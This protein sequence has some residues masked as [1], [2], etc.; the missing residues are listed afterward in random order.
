MKT[1]DLFNFQFVDREY[2]RKKMQKFLSENSGNAL[3]IKGKRGFGKTKLFHYVMKEYEDHILCYI[4]IKP[5][6]SSM[7]TLT[8]FIINLQN[9]CSKDFISSV[10]EKYTR[11]YNHT[12]KHIY[13]ISKDILPDISKIVSLILDLGYYAITK[14]GESKSPIELINDYIRMILA[15]NK[16]CICID[17]FSRCNIDLAQLFFQIIKAFI[18]DNN[19]KACIVTTS[20][21]IKDELNEAIFTHLPHKEISIKKLDKYNYFYQILEPIFEINQLTEED[22]IFLYHKCEGSPK[23]LCTII[24]KLL[25]KEGITI[26]TKGKARINRSKLLEILHNNRVRFEDG[27]FTS[28]QKWII[29]SFLCLPSKVTIKLMKEL[30]LY[31][32][33]RCFLYNA[34]DETKFDRELLLL[35][36][37]KILNY[38]IPDIISTNHDLD[39]YELTDIFKDSTLREMF[40]QYTYEFLL[41]KKNVPYRQELLCKHAYEA[42]IAG[43]ELLNFRY[44]KKLFYHKR[45]YDAY[46]VL[47]RLEFT[48]HKLNP[49]QR[50]FS[51]LVAYEAGYYKASIKKMELIDF[52]E[53]KF[54]KAKYY[55]LFYLGKNYYN[56][57]NI[58]KAVIML[59]KSLDFVPEGSLKY[60]QTLN[61]LHMYYFEIP[62]KLKLS[63]EIFNHI[64]VTYEDKYPIAWANTMRGCHNFLDNKSA[65]NILERAKKKLDDEL[66]K[67]FIENTQGFVF[68][69]MSQMV[70]A[71]NKFR[72][73]GNIIKRLR[74]HEY[75]YVAN[76]LAL[77]YMIKQKYEIAKT[78]LL[79]ALL[80]N[81]TNYGNLVLQTHLMMC[82]FYLHELD[83]ASY[84]SKI[85][86]EYMAS[87]EVVDP[88]INRKVYM[89]LAIFSAGIKSPLMEVAYFKKAEPFVK[90]SSSEWRYNFLTKEGN[91]EL[92][93]PNAEYMQVI[94]FDP[95]FL[96]YAHD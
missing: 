17:N 91:I 89:N 53:L 86:E 38:S 90:D 65:L 88:I 76:N 44:A 36:D 6:Q 3:W 92:P 41:M 87:N 70:E 14:N 74:I 29:F 39:Y 62:E 37:N 10:S 15:K 80:W 23:K 18:G 22:L 77:C 84:Y 35:V 52:K 75:S 7:D 93:R 21:D 9:N 28:V 31:I 51:A 66:E 13:N 82:S 78:L 64:Q 73:A 45:I 25:E 43:W 83:E 57:G 54:L 27:D 4:D 47:L 24:S 12:Y 34:F 49:L 30:A 32:S 67:A 59:K 60:V 16:L 20:E 85:L 68:I 81:K 79:E 69:K 56:V 50:L 5:N 33:Q 48:D 63:E 55:Y 94:K 1:T 2:E 95:W 96:V 61:V 19:F 71:E 46:S 40:S 58:K 26:F 11:F 42:N 8:D 72:E